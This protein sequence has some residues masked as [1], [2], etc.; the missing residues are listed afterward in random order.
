MRKPI[1]AKGG[2][3]WGKGASPITGNT[4]SHFRAACDEQDAP[5]ALSDD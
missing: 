1:C 4:D 5:S 3:E 2:S